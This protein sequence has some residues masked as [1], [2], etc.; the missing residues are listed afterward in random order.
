MTFNLQWAAAIAISMN[1]YTKTLN[2]SNP[3]EQL[4]FRI[5]NLIGFLIMAWM[6]GFEWFRLSLKLMTVL[7]DDNEW[8]MLAV[9]SVVIVLMSAFNL[10]L[11]IYP[12]ARKMTKDIN[13]GSSFGGKKKDLL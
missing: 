6:R 1:E 4:K 9:G 5:L 7:H 8:S 12:F 11:C 13:F 2:L 3:T 10:I